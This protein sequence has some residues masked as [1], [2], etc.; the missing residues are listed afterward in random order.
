MAQEVD[1]TLGLKVVDQGVKIRQVI[2]EPKIVDL[3]GV[4]Q[5]KAAPVGRDDASACG[6][7][8]WQGIDHELVRGGHVHPAVGQH[9]RRR[10][11]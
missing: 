8:L 5:A 2:G 4:G 9:E 1:R 3:A 6:K 7:G 11:G 10:I